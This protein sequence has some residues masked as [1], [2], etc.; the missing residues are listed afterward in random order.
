MTSEQKQTLKEFDRRQEKLEQQLKALLER[1][2]EYVN[3]NQLN[4]K[5][6]VK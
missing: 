2:R 5:V 3:T 1:R 4:E 6:G